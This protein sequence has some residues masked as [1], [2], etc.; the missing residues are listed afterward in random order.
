MRHATSGGENERGEVSL[1]NLVNS[2]L[3]LAIFLLFRFVEEGVVGF[4]EVASGEW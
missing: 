3:V 4:T 1:L 2:R